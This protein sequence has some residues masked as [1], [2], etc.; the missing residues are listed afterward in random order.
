MAGGG[1]RPGRCG[2]GRPRRPGYGP[3]R[4][5]PQP[6]PGTRHDPGTPARAGFSAPIPPLGP[7]TTPGLRPAPGL[8]PPTHPWHPGLGRALRPQPTRGTPAWSR[9][10]T[11][12]IPAAPTRGSF[13]C[14][15]P[16]PGCRGR[17]PRVPSRR[18]QRPTVPSRRDWVGMSPPAR[19][20][21]GT[22]FTLRRIAILSESGEK[23]SGGEETGDTRVTTSHDVN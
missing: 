16:G 8:V 21:T 12:P 6:T 14:S 7:G 11:S 15:P 1:A 10:C 4:S 9:G 18:R 3:P 13:P 2:E 17:S 19:S 20:R 22:T 23:K 5:L